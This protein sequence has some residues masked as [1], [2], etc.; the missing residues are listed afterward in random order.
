MPGKTLN[1]RRRPVRLHTA[2]IAPDFGAATVLAHDPWEYVSLALRRQKKTDETL[3]YWE[4]AR[5]FFRASQVLPATASPL[6]SY[7]CVLN[8]AKA[9][10]AHRGASV[11][12][13]HG[14]SGDKKGKKV[15]LQNEV[16]TIC[17]G[18]VLPALSQVMGKALSNDVDLTLEDLLA[19]LPFVHRAFTLTYKSADELFVPLA[20]VHFET[21]PKTSECW[22]AATVDAKYATGQL[23]NALP[24]D[25][26][27]DVGY[28]EA[29]VVRMKPR[30]QWKAKQ[31]TASINRLVS[32]HRRVR[33]DVVPIIEPL[34]RWYLRRRGT[35]A[36]GFHQAVIIFAAL[37]RLSELSRYD[38]LRLR[39]HLNARHNWLV[40][41]FLSLGPAQFIHLVSSEITGQEFLAPSAARL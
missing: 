39:A 37:H 26:E 20:D 41:E 3:F 7:Y 36:G 24:Q 25:W 38:P 15:A 28:D 33:L 18:G 8:A 30:F 14:A 17:T 1:L 2:T 29:F 35:A 34:N 12:P 9:L 31:K 4:Q 22:F 10:L 23:A 32:Y 6:T 21:H 27:Q 5:G 11:P 16:V 13:R 40:T 19:D